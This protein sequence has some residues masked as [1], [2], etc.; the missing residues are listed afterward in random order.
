MFRKI[1]V[2]DDDPITR[3]LVSDILVKADFEVLTAE[4]GLAALNL[5]KSEN[6]DLVILDVMMPEVN[7]YDVCYQLRFNSDFKQIPIILITSR[8]K[9]LD[10]MIGDRADIAY[11]P[12]PIDSDGL[13][14]KINKLLSV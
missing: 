14:E 3:H 7:G 6:P 11:L 10:S 5:I 2:A 13:I 1:L 12:K 9:E 4:D 8:D